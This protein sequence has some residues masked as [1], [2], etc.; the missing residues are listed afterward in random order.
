MPDIGGNEING[1]GEADRR[2]PTVIY[3][4]DPSTLPFGD[5]MMWYVR[6]NYQDDA[7]R[8]RKEA[9]AIDAV[10]LAPVSGRRAA[11]PAGG[12]TA[13]VKAESERLAVAMV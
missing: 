3:W 7:L 5:L 13:R 12:W 2:R 10:E 11:E 1:L 9:E 8:I 6:R 4:N